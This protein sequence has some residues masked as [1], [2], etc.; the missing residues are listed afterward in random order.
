MTTVMTRRNN[1]ADSDDEPSD[2]RTNA[3]EI[4]LMNLSCAAAF[5]ITAD[6]MTRVYVNLLFNIDFI[7][8]I[9][10]SRSQILI[11]GDISQEEDVV[12]EEY[13]DICAAAT[14]IADLMISDQPS[15]PLG[16]GTVT[17]EDLDFKALVDRHRQHQTQQAA[18][19]SVRTERRAETTSRRKRSVK[20]LFV[21][22]M[23]Y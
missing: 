7:F 6:E 21:A 23:K 1:G 2:A 22:S 14:C 12:T 18:T 8:L 20:G 4:E 17:A 5:A 13:L 9:S 16:L 15:K 3:Q 19:G 10:I 11:N